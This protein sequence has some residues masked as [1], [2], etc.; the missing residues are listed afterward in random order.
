MKKI[1]KI[2]ALSIFPV[3]FF[4]SFFFLLIVKAKTTTPPL[5]KKLQKKSVVDSLSKNSTKAKEHFKRGWEY[6]QA[7]KLDLA[8]QEYC[9][10]LEL[11]PNLSEAHLNLGMNYILKKEFDNA[12]RE[13]KKALRQNPKL[14]TAH[15][16]LW[17]AY[18]QQQKYDQGIEELK[19]VIAIDPNDVNAYINLGDTYLTDKKMTLEAISAYS[20]GLAKNQNDL[21]L[22]RRVGKAYELNQQWDEAIKRFQQAINLKTDDPYSYLF[23]YVALKKSGKNSDAKATVQKALSVLKGNPLLANSFETTYIL[24]YLAGAYSEKDLLANQNP[25]IVC[26]ANYYIGMNY[27]FDK[28]IKKAVQ[29]FQQ[30]IDT[31]IFFLSE[32][33]YAKIELDRIRGKKGKK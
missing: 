1:V 32:Y 14:K 13:L 12:I 29:Y 4:I 26:Q 19:K 3:V 17:W 16:N 15:F 30:A 8:I 31:D 9:K 27:L 28:K 6:N 7:K 22:H 20:Q 25:L 2:T 21:S 5:E 23:L 11:D 18:R 33:E 24:K 10:A